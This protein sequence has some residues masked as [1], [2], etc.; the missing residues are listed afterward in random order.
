MN[1]ETDKKTLTINF[2]LCD[3]IKAF[4]GVDC[5]D[6]NLDEKGIINAIFCTGLEK[7]YKYEEVETLYFNYLE[8]KDTIKFDLRNFPKFPNLK[9]LSTFC[10][11]K[12]FDFLDYFPNLEFIHL[13]ET[14]QVFDPLMKINIKKPL[15]NLKHIIFLESDFWRIVVKH[16]HLFPNIEKFEFDNFDDEINEFVHSE[17]LLLFP[18]LKIVNLNYSRFYEERSIYFSHRSYY[19]EQP[20]GTAYIPTKFMDQLSKLKDLEEI[21][22]LLLENLDNLKKFKKLKKI[23]KLRCLYG[24]YEKIRGSEEEIKVLNKATETLDV[25]DKKFF[26]LD[27]E[28]FDYE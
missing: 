10:S 21:D 23:K 18:N 2:E 26:K 11:L 19:D 16:N 27:W 8:G 13:R 20:P 15:E 14:S 17:E 5:Y 6:E 7:I 25:K 3:E 12:N 4:R 22:Y 24:E 9:K 1:N 28:E